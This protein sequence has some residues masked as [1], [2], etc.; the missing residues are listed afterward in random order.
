MPHRPQNRQCKSWKPWS[1]KTPRPLKPKFF[2]DATVG[3]SDG[4]KDIGFLAPDEPESGG[5]DPST[6][7]TLEPDAASKLD[8]PALAG[9]LGSFESG[10]GPQSDVEAEP[11]TAEET[12][13]SSQSSSRKKSRMNSRMPQPSRP[14]RVQWKILSPAP[15]PSA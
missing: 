2:T 8:S 1:L 6:S 14:W 13:Q 12:T 3:D 15:T 11:G 9:D 7:P 5:N 4:L 10:E